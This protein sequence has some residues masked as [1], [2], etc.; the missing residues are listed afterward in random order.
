MKI[1]AKMLTNESLVE[2]V[3]AAIENSLLPDDVLLG[4]YKHGLI[5][6]VKSI[7]R[8]LEALGKKA[9]NKKLTRKEA[10][11]IDRKQY[12]LATLGNKK[13]AILKRLENATDKS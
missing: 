3:D 5:S 10:V 2:I 8:Q 9:K 1:T 12:R 6:Q 13:I 4:W 11:A 7:Q